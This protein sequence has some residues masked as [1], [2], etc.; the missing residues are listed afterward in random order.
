MS[1]EYTSTEEELEYTTVKYAT[2][3]A[4]ANYVWIGMTTGMTTMITSCQDCSMPL[5]DE[6]DIKVRLCESCQDKLFQQRPVSSDKDSM[7]RYRATGAEK[8]HRKSAPGSVTQA[9]TI[10]RSGTT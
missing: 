1:I 6:E 9:R 10:K 2:V 4:P 5:T 3:V 8:A 7:G